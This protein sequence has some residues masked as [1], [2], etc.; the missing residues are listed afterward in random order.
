MEETHIFLC[1]NGNLPQSVLCCLDF[2][3]SI[4]RKVQDTQKIKK[5]ANEIQQSNECNSERT[6]MLELS[7]NK[8]KTTMIKNNYD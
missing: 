1:K 8:F 4:N 2:Q 3:N 5:E 6:P 7:G